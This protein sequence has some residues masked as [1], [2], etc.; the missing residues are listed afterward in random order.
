[1]APKPRYNMH[2]LQDRIPHSRPFLGENE[3]EAAA[4]V[5]RSGQIAQG[6]RVSAFESAMARRIGVRHAVAVSSGTAALY[7]VLRSL[8][9][10]PGDEVIIPSYVCFAL[11]NAVYHSGAVCVPADVDPETGNINPADA[12][13]RVN[14]RTKAVVV[15]HLFGNPA[16]VSPFLGSGIK[17]IEDCAQAVGA[18]VEAEPAGSVGHVGVFSFYATKVITTG[19]GGMV[20]TNDGD[21]AGM[22]KSLRDYDSYCDAVA[23][24]NYKMTD[25]QAAIG[26]VQ[27]ARLDSFIRKR[28][29]IAAM[30]TEAFSSIGLHGINV[31]DG[32]IYYRY[33]IATEGADEADRIISG[34]RKI[35]V[36]ASRPVFLPVH[37]RMGLSGF[38]GC[39]MAHKRFVSIP[40]YP[41]MRDSEINRVIES[42]CKVVKGGSH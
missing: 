10:G 32:G 13:A 39:E 7:L 30:Y 4:S 17:V 31:K 41:A 14:R 21:I 38:P 26:M 37:R 42:V 22:V 6:P 25:I 34:L 27:L 40:I 11:C 3:A 24:F 36:D 33:V 12:L 16:P 19:E 35:G 9:I 18:E 23:R 28:R 8:G 2:N 1:M 20:L 5:I 15:V 29:K